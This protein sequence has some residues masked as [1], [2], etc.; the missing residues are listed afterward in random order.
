MLVVRVRAVVP[1]QLR[2][3]CGGGAGG[4]TGRR[5]GPFEMT[6]LDFDRENV[7]NARRENGL[8]EFYA[9]FLG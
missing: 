1:R 5:Q 8:R 3:A 4:R 7:S 6:D 2:S 9:R